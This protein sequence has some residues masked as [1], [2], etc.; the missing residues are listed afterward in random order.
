MA[1][2]SFEVNLEH[3]L[4]MMA[5]CAEGLISLDLLSGL[6]CVEDEDIEDLLAPMWEAGTIQALMYRDAPALGL[7]DDHRQ[8]LRDQGI[9]EAVKA[10]F[11]T[12]ITWAYTI[13]GW[14]DFEQKERWLNHAQEALHLMRASGDARIRKWLYSPFY[15]FCRKRGHGQLYLDTVDA[16]LALPE[17]EQRDRSA[18]LSNKAMIHRD[19]GQ[20][21]L[22]LTLLQEE[23][24]ICR[25]LD[26]PKALLGCFGNQALVHQDRDDL[27]AA[28][29]LYKKEIALCETHDDLRGLADSYNNLGLILIEQDLLDEAMAIY[30]KQEA[31]YTS[32]EDTRGLSC[33]YGNQA[34]IY[35]AWGENQK[36]LAL[37]QK[38]QAL[39]EEEGDLI[40]LAICYY[41]QGIA[42]FDLEDYDTARALLNQAKDY[43]EKLE[44][45]IDIAEWHW[46]MGRLE[47]KAR[48]P[49]ASLEHFRAHRDKS[50]D[51]DI[52]P[53]EN[54]D[55]IIEAIEEEMN[56]TGTTE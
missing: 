50:R 53:H 18:A 6:M 30:K 24:A 12:W 32:F 3:L 40:G 22:A 28:M 17:L 35:N 45:W 23:E 16:A 41:N 42:H 38:E 37:H 27:E 54:A 39:C 26:D 14:T 15:S 4:S 33:C 44:Q 13:K 10:H 11:I 21:D 25:T 48:N 9:P 1:K 2:P 52:E 31:L 7:K 5:Q 47:W 55:Q 20:Y 36:A 51:A 43:Y 34:R 49:Q 56:E 19:K 8:Q 29:T 46:T